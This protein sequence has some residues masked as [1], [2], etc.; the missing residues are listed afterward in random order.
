MIEFKVLLK[1]A[2]LLT[3]GGGVPEVLGADVVFVKM[4]GENGAEPYIPGS[5]V[6]GSLRTSATRIA[7]HYG[8]TACGEIEPARIK[9]AHSTKGICDVCRL[10][11]YPDQRGGDS[12]PLFVSDFKLVASGVESVLVTRVGLDRKRLVALEGALYTVEHLPPGTLFEGFIGLREEAIGLLPLLLLGMAELR[13]SA[14]GHRSLVD[15]KIEDAGLL[16]KYVQDKWRPLLQ[17]LR[18]W[19]WEGVV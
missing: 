3:V 1:S 16:D 17:G 9:R 11:G 10:F 12:S 15:M 13:T 4:P 18:E 19:L 8:F 7:G 6:K 2:T 14:F 5:S